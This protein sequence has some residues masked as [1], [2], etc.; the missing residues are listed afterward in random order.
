[1]KKK[2]LVVMLVLASIVGI[3][4]AV[5]QNYCATAKCFECKAEYH[6]TIGAPTK[7]EAIA[8]AKSMIDHKKGCSKTKSKIRGVAYLGMCPAAPASE[9]DGE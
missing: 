1:M 9:N 3:V 4:Y 6:D 2:I 5:E 8:Q 7:K